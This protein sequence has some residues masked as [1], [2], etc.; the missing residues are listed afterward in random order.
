MSVA[1]G[2]GSSHG[3]EEPGHAAPVAGEAVASSHPAQIP[4]APDERSISPARD[5][6]ASPWPGRL[7]FWPAVWVGVAFLFYG[8]ATRW[9]G[10]VEP[11][12]G[13]P[14]PHGNPGSHTNDGSVD[15]SDPVR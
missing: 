14:G 13:S 8:A 15:A 11:S 5:E 7:L 12:H 10:P 6:Y 9:S 3:H 1:H 2:H 4:S